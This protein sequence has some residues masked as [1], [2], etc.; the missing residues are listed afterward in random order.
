M[1]AAT[2]FSMV[3]AMHMQHVLLNTPKPM[4]EQK[5]NYLVTMVQSLPQNL[6]IILTKKYLETIHIK[7]NTFACR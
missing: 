4:T 5:K 2:I 6:I 7:H 3:F 1:I